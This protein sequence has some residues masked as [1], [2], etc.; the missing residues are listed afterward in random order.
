MNIIHNDS[1]IVVV[2]KPGGLLA[3]PGRGPDKQDCVTARVRH[4]F[5]EMITQPSVHRLD[6]YTSGVMVL[7]K[8]QEAHRNLSIQF[9]QRRTV[10]VYIAV[11]EGILAADKGRVE[12]KF[13]LD[14]NNRP[15]QIF[16]P[17][18]GKIGITLWEKIRIENTTTRIRMQPLTGRTHQLRIHAAHE[19]GLGMPI[20]GDR[21]YGN[22]RE[23]EQMMLHAYQLTLEHPHT[24]KTMLFESTVPF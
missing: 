23:G 9:E 18:H 10:K 2:D 11:I 5:P 20:V 1:H 14:I 17:V 15:Y 6:M 12:L 21:L 19:R 22:G 8:T 16:D 4:Q 13:R 3:V 24:G 7:A